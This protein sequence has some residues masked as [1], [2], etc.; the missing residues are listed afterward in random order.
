MSIDSILQ[1]IQ[2]NLFSS[3]YSV[4]AYNT[5]EQ[6]LAIIQAAIPE[7]NQMKLFCIFRVNVIW[8]P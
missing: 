8:F 2:F 3:I 7:L 6:I 4:S 1:F 5:N